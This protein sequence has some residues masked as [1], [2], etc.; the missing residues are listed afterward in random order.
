[1]KIFLSVFFFMSILFVS[2]CGEEDSKIVDNY[3]SKSCENYQI[4]APA[5][6]F[7]DYESLS[8]CKDECAIF[9]QAQIDLGYLESDDCGSAYEKLM[10]CLGNNI[11]V[12]NCDS[13]GENDPDQI[14][15]IE[16]KLVD[17]LCGSDDEEED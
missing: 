4:C 9:I 8:R 17:A 1:M 13:E 10:K 7:E 2:G 5:D 15:E 11:N 16:G 14:C 12:K 3:C 6:F